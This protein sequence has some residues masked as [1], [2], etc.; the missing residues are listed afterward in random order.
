MERG[1]SAPKGFLFFS[2]AI[3]NFV[4]KFC[5]FVSVVLF[6]QQITSDRRVICNVDNNT[7]LCLDLIALK[8][9]ELEIVINLIMIL[10]FAS[11]TV[12]TETD[13][14]NQM[15][16]KRKSNEEHSCCIV[17][18]TNFV[19]VKK[20]ELYSISI[21]E[22]TNVTFLRFPASFLD[23]IKEAFTL[24][25]TFRKMSFVEECQMNE[26]ANFI[27]VVLQVFFGSF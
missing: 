11:V 14:E 26:R 17:I 12:L 4:I 20:I 19:C 6:S 18:S 5:F 23:L 13:D 16:E 10:D 21:H 25:T 8:K 7:R 9:E 22:P 2:T 1:F 27:G 3:N 15:V 24:R